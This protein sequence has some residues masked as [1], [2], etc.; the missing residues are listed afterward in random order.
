ME[1]EGV[2]VSPYERLAAEYAANPREQPFSFYVVW[3]MIHGFVFSAP[4][5]FIMGRAI[6]KAYAERNGLELVPHEEAPMADTWYLHAFSGDMAKA[7]SILPY[8][9]PYIAWERMRAKRL[10]LTVVAF[11][12]IRQ[13]THATDTKVP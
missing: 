13:M 10:D 4:D 6:N 5:F 9:L 8:P 3:H 1:R 7:W 11:D 2:A 12:R